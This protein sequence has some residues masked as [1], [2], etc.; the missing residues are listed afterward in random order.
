M[1]VEQWQC[2]CYYDPPR[3]T[4]RFLLFLPLL[5]S[6]RTSVDRQRTGS[7][8]PYL[9]PRTRARD[10][11]AT[12]HSVPM[13]NVVMK[14]VSVSRWFVSVCGATVSVAMARHAHR[15]GVSGLTDTSFS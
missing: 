11:C 14:R 2:W 6:V 13:N 3:R 4:V 5:L 15:A 12:W 7:L 8:L 10:A 9:A 1:G